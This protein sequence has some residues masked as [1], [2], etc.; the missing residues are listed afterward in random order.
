MF[1][2]Y[3]FCF[4][5]LLSGCS[6]FQPLQDKPLG[7]DGLLF[8][9][10]AGEWSYGNV[11]VDAEVRGWMSNN[12]SAIRLAPGHYRLTGFTRNYGYQGKYWRS[13][14]MNIPFTVEAGKV[15]SLGKLAI[16]KAGSKRAIVALTDPGMAERYLQSHYPELGSHLAAS[17]YQQ[18]DI[19]YLPEDKL[20]DFRLS[21]A[22]TNLLALKSQGDVSFGELGIVAVGQSGAR[23][24]VPTQT[25]AALQPAVQHSAVGEHYFVD[26]FGDIYCY[27][28]NDIVPLNRA[29]D[30]PVAAL[31]VAPSLWVAGDGV[32]GLQVSSNQGGDWAT[33]SVR[34]SQTYTAPHFSFHDDLLFAGPLTHDYKA[35]DARPRGVIFDVETGES[36]AIGWSEYV[37][38]KTR[39]FRVGD[40]YIFDPVNL[41]GRTTFLFRYDEEDADWDE[42]RLPNRQCDIEVQAP[43]IKLDCR[44]GSNFV[45]IDA[46]RH[47]SEVISS[48]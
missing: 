19:Q 1:Q 18:A 6:S 11:L 25:L 28:D 35:A 20:S 14:S 33:H 44:Q 46:G 29:P 43:E 26:S 7:K 40:D 10:T 21:F 4:L 48:P 8:F 27:C 2:R 17:D 5:F 36:S 15:T 47:W 3:W 30:Q 31:A 32:G 16:Y 45:S 34:L 23:R 42:V 41:D 9:S 13:L 38:E 22:N 37:T 39:F 24:I 12:Y